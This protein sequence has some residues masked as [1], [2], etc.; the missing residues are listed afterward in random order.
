MSTYVGDKRLGY[1]VT[2]V[3]SNLPQSTAVA[4]FNVSGKVLVNL[5]VGEVTTIIQTQSNDT[6]LQSNPATG[7]TNDMCAALNIS[8]KEVGTLFSI[9]GVA[10]D[11]MVAGSSGAVRGQTVPVIVAKGAIELY[12]AASNSGKAKWTCFYIPIDDGAVVTAA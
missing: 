9:T 11:A 10:G 5:I 6:N 12:C 1:K 2:R 7:T 4:L 8:A 3:T